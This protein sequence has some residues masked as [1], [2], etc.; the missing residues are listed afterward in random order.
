MN[1]FN[2]RGVEYILITDLKLIYKAATEVKSFDEK[3]D[4]K[5]HKEVDKSSKRLWSNH[6]PASNIFWRKNLDLSVW[7]Y[8]INKTDYFFILLRFF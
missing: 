6:I 2:S 7:K 3:W 1:E 5:Y 8:K 4:K